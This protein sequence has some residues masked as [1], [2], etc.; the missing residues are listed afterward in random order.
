[1]EWYCSQIGAREHYAVPRAL[2]A[3]SRLAR[4]YTDFWC[5]PGSILAKVSGRLSGRYH[6]DLLR[7]D[8]QSKNITS[9]VRRMFLQKLHDPY[10]RE[11][12]YGKWFAACVRSHMKISAKITGNTVYFSYDTSFLEAA[13]Y[14]KEAGGKCV[15]CQMDPSEYEYE[16]VKHECSKWP[17]WMDTPNIPKEYLIRRKAEW[18]VADKIL[19]NSE[20][21]K[22]ALIKQNVDDGKIYVIPLCFES[23]ATRSPHVG[24][25]KHEPGQPVRVLWLGNVILRKGIQYLL[26]AARLLEK[27]N[28]VV[29]I[30]GSVLIHPDVLADIPK[31]VTFHGPC[32]RHAVSY[33]YERSDV[34]V[35]P[36]LSDGFAITQLE[37]MHY[38]LPVITTDCCGR[39]VDN[40]RDGFIVPSGD[41]KSLAAAINFFLEH[42]ELL[43]DFSRAAQAKSKLF[44]MQSLINNLDM[45]E[46]KLQ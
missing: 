16:I 15:V 30:V 44:N 42:K 20:W 37:A 22:N 45:L 7:Q 28:V 14:V 38:G 24:R 43:Q 5:P 13:E 23:P 2:S 29:D 4:L 10:T 1:M 26:D 18:E 9:L 32:Q 31:Q 3:N 21:T 40:G 17:G 27:E 6:Q 19:V 34:F 12:Q 36:T 33:W 8:V 41:S 25:K 46:Q 35:L 11:V 39:V